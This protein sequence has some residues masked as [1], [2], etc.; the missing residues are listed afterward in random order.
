MRRSKHGGQRRAQGSGSSD[1]EMADGKASTSAQSAS[2]TRRKLVTSPDA[3]DIEFLDLDEE[4]DDPGDNVSSKSSQSEPA[5]QVHQAESSQQQQQPPAAVYVA[6][7][8][9]EQ[10]AA[11]QA[12]N[13][14]RPTL[15]PASE[16]LQ[17][18]TSIVTPPTSP[19]S[20]RPIRPAYNRSSSAGASATAVAA[21][22]YITRRSR[23]PPSGSSGAGQDAGSSLSPST[24]MSKDYFAQVATAKAQRAHSRSRSTSGRSSNS[25]NSIASSSSG[26]GSD[27]SSTPGLIHSSSDGS[28]SDSST[29]LRTPS[30]AQPMELHLPSLQNQK[31]SKDLQSCQL[32]AERGTSGPPS[33]KLRPRLYRRATYTA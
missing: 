18:I 31:N 22:R 12:V 5:S 6:P 30:P 16:V 4:L 26:S 24:S 11:I 7:F 25:S 28:S 29:E 20:A 33:P 3:D 19:P 17:P 14:N 10:I 32:Q 27:S 15:K 8:S 1:E 13:R 2:T 23:S 21:P 9:A